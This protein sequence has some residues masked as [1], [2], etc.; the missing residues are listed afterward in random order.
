MIFPK[1]SDFQVFRCQNLKKSGFSLSFF[2]LYKYV[3]I[4]DL[5]KTNF[6]IGKLESLDGR[7]LVSSILVRIAGALQ[8]NQLHWSCIHQEHHEQLSSPTPGERCPCPS[9]ARAF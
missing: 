4:V 7:D 3:P 6:F 1:I 9:R 2:C 8:C 5:S